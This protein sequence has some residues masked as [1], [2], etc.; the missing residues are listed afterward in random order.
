MSEQVLVTVSHNIALRCSVVG[1]N[2]VCV[3]VLK[4]KDLKSARRH[5]CNRS[6]ANQVLIDTLSKTELSD[7][8]EKIFSETT[9]LTDTL[10]C[11]LKNYDVYW[12]VGFWASCLQ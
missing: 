9:V 4:E 12:Q 7:H 10:H 1:L 8:P 5:V 3:C 2:C 6:S 11:T